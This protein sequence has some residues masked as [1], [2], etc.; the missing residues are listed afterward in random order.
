MKSKLIFLFLLISIF[1]FSQKKPKIG[2]VLSGGGAKGIAHIG[3]LRYLESKGIKP[4]Y[5]VG[6][7]MGALIGGLYAIGYTP[8]ELE[9]IVKYRDWDYLLN[10]QIKRK[11]VLIG[12]GDKNKNVLITLPLDG[13][14]PKMASGLYKGQNILTFFEIMTRDYNRPISFDSL[15]IPFRCIATN[16]ETGEEKIFTKGKLPDV[17]RASMSIPSVFAPYEING[18]LYIDGGIVNNFPTDVVKAMGADIIIGVDVGAVLYEKEE[19]NSIIKILDQTSSFYN[20]RIAQENKK[21]C[22]IYIRPNIDGISAM[23]F[24]E[25]DTIINRGY[26]A[27]KKSENKIDSVFGKYS[28]NTIKDMHRPFNTNQIINIDTIKIITDINNFGHK[29]GTKRLIMGKL[30]I[31]TPITITEGALTDRINRLYGSKYFKRI[32]MQFE[33]TTDTSYALIL[34]V[35]EKKENDFSIGARFDQQYGVN[36]LL[37]AQFRNLMLYGS[38][39]ELRAVAGQSPQFRARYTTDRGA[40]LGF[41]SSMEYNNFYVYTYQ[42]SKKFAEYNYN[43]I[44]ADLFIHSYLGNYNRIVFGAEYSSFLLSATQ[45]ISDIKDINNNYFN[46]YGSYVV[47]TWDRAYYP[48]KGFQLKVRSDLI[49]HEQDKAMNTAWAKANIIF[50]ISKKLKVIAEGFIGYG[51]NNI[52]TTLFRYEV[53]GMANNHIEWYNS[54]PGLQY[55]EQGSN[56]IW[57]AKLSPRYEFYKNNF[58]TATIA[59]TAMD[60]IFENLFLKADRMY[61]GVGI[62]YG[63][64]SMFGPLEISADYAFNSYNTNYFIS[65]GYW[66]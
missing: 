1:S 45:T 65:L 13:L 16:I 48:N 34:S 22:D 39:L 36:V 47:D 64:N 18:E 14:S 12:Q 57:I 26:I 43:R 7:S 41:G 53:G 29:Y 5:I 19:I 46:L 55:L 62:K 3:A 66:F 6:T 30:K 2:L 10:D 33:P 20:F 32:S 28:L 9:I 61:T 50:P 49:F 44:M 40:S 52:D 24:T 27:T 11:N 42:D 35:S 15:E 8:D 63:F 23:D 31:K 51:T 38:L 21:L 60:N 37:A 4:D 17:M 54:M 25:T 56:N 58:I 59:M